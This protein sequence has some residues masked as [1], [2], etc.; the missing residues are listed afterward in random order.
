MIRSITITNYLDES[1]E[2]ELAKP[3][4]S[5]FVVKSITGLG[6]SQ[7]SINTTEVA[8]NDGSI[9]NSSRLSSRNIVLTLAFLPNDTIETTRQ[10]SYKYFP[11]KKKLTFR[12]DTDNRQAEV[13]GY[14]ES[15][16]PTI[17][18]EE[19]GTTISIICPDPYFYSV[20]DL[21]KDTTVFYGIEPNFEF[22]FANES[23]T[24]NKLMIGSIQRKSE[25]VVV[26]NGDAEIGITIT[27]HAVG[28]ASNIAIYNSRTQEA[29]KIDTDKIKKITGSGIVFGDDII[30]STVRGNKSIKL[31]RSGKSTNILNCL[32]KNTDW[33]QLTKGDNVFAYTADEG[34][35]NLQFKI[36]NRV[37]FEGV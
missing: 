28:T 33:F 26:Y 13:E 12:V 36:E 22:P 34:S 2:L 30:I 35:S 25:N 32:D 18:S 1:I 21:E 17:F 24:S 31:Q 10:L 6:P 3:E 4:K 15:N 9:Y 37:A 20:S 19:E 29:M 5:G 27:I 7:A 14:V 16:E 11:V 8:T 23:L